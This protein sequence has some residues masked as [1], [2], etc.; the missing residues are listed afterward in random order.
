MPFFAPGFY[1]DI[2]DKHEFDY[3]GKKLIRINYGN[4]I[5]VTED[6]AEQILRKQPQWVEVF[7]ADG[8]FFPVNRLL[9]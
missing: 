7:K 1:K 2:Y 3:Q 5:E 6:H 4:V 9:G 8:R